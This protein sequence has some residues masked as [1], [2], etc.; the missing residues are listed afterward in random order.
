MKMRWIDVLTHALLR[1]AQRGKPP[2]QSA[3]PQAAA[4]PL[5]R[6]PFKQPKDRTRVRTPA[7]HGCQG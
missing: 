4:Q 3:Q 6:H 1:L 5:V 7:P 2:T